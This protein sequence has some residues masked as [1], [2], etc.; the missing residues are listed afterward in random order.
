M[1]FLF[2]MDLKNVEQL[3]WFIIYFFILATLFLETFANVQPDI[4]KF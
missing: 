4:L 1:I 3:F 2:Y